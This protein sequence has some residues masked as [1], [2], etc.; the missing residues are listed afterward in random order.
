MKL[1]N[2]F[3]VA[4][5]SIK[6]DKMMSAYMCEFVSYNVLDADYVKAKNNK[7]LVMDDIE[8]E[9]TELETTELE[10]TELETTELET[11]ELETT[12]LETKEL[13]TK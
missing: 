3:V 5:A 10:T 8:L 2:S 4:H 1:Y 6:S 11:T 7:N 12:E 13:E 9:T